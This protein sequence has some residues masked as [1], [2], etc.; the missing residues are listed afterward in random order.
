MRNQKEK[1][2]EKRGDRAEKVQKELEMRFFP[3][4]EETATIRRTTAL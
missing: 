3:T 1:S 2:A 4:S